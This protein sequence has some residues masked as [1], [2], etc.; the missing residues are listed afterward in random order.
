MKFLAIVCVLAANAFGSPDADATRRIFGRFSEAD[1][2]EIRRGALC[3]PGRVKAR[4]LGEVR[5]ATEVQGVLSHL[6][7][8]TVI[9]HRSVDPDTG[10]EVYFRG[11]VLI[12]C[13]DYTLF[14][15]RG[16]HQLGTIGLLG[17]SGVRAQGE[18][19]DRVLAE[20]SRLFLV[21]RFGLVEEPDDKQPKKG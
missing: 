5:G 11:M 14:F 9:S 13:P 15:F 6:I 21:K 19:E 16:E 2:V 10:E 17:V 4:I 3:H 7:I 20:A 8:E 18:K 12:A 1:R